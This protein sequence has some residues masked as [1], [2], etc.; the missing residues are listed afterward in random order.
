MAAAGERRFTETLRLP[1]PVLRWWIAFNVIATVFL[2]WL[3]S[4]ARMS[5]GQR[6]GVAAVL[7]FLL[8]YLWG[9]ALWFAASHVIV[10]GGELTRRIGHK[11]TRTAVSDI[12]AFRVESGEW[13]PSNV[14]LTLRDGSEQEIPTRQPDELRRALGR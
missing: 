13:A 14:I 10:R 11:R 9:G 2:G 1:W 8:L 3:W 4:I 12:A 7:V 5:A 6:V